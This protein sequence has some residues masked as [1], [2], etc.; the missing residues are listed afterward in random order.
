[1]HGFMCWM[2]LYMQENSVWT[3]WHRDVLLKRNAVEN[4]SQWACG[5]VLQLHIPS[6]EIWLIYDQEPKILL[7]LVSLEILK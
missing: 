1:M 7:K 6:K 2:E 5:Y 4:V 3:E